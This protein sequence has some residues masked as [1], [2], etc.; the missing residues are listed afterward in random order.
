M[1]SPLLLL[2][3]LPIPSFTFSASTTTAAPVDQYELAHRWQ[4]GLFDKAPEIP[5]TPLSE[6]SLVL[7]KNGCVRVNNIVDQDN[8]DR[9][10]SR[11]LFMLSA[12]EGDWTA[13]GS[14]PK[15]NRH[16]SG[17]RL[18][19]TEPIDN[20][21]GGLRHDVLLPLLEDEVSKVL[22]E[23]A[24]TLS[25]ILKRAVASEVEGR[26]GGGLGGGLCSATTITNHLLLV[27]S[28]FTA[29]RSQ[30]FP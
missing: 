20:C 4:S 21:F 5:V 24:I 30:H 28:L 29:A 25:P 7:K 12:G 26:L 22:N 18:R 6:A 17:T 1:H 9:L 19:F 15:D 23:A 14:E 3:L 27:T 10:K 13:Q 2:F 8:C 16:V 11:I